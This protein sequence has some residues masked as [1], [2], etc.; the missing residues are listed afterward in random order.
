MTYICESLDSSLRWNDKLFHIN[1]VKE[2][3]YKGEYMIRDSIRNIPTY[4]MML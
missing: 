2:Q 4:R 3:L 1:A